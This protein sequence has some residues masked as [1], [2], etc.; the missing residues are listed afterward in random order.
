MPSRLL[1]NASN[2][3][4]VFLNVVNGSVGKQG[5]RA[6][7][8]PV[9]PHNTFGQDFSASEEVE[10]DEFANAHFSHA[11]HRRP[12]MGFTTQWLLPRLSQG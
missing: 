4:N 6:P 7:Q 9:P 5:A 2:V 10:D 11:I 12:V 8:D 1:S 3:S